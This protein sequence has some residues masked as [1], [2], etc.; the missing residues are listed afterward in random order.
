MIRER[1]STYQRNQNG[2]REFLTSNFDCTNRFW[3]VNY[4]DFIAEVCARVLRD[5]TDEE[6]GKYY[7]SRTYLHTSRKINDYCKPSN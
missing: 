4:R 6:R 2:V 3:K 1:R 5:F 7:R